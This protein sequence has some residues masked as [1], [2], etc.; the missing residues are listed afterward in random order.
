M[1][2]ILGSW[3]NFFSILKA[4]IKLTLF[5]V[6]FKEKEMIKVHDTNLIAVHIVLN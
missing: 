2:I 3:E 6:K 5:K 4:F 1:E